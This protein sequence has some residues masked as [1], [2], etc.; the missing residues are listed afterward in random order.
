MVCISLA[1]GMALFGGVA[2]MEW[3]WP[4]CSRCVTVG[5]G[6]KTLLLAA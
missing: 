6:F 4:Y 5:I 1:Q 3:V 2:L